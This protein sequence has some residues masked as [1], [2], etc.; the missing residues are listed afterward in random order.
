MSSPRRAAPV[1]R[2][3]GAGR[4]GS[5]AL[6]ALVVLL[7][8]GG[9]GCWE[10]WSET[11]FPQ[12]KWQKAIQ[13]FERVGV[14]DQ[15][16]GFQPPEGTVPVGGIEPSIGR[17]DLEEAARLENPTDPADFRSLTRGK[18][19]YATYC[20]VC[21]GAAGMGDGPVSIAGEQQG[22]FIGVFPLATATGQSD[23]YIW[24]VIRIGNGDTPGY[25]MPGY[26]HIPSLDRWHI[27]NYVRYLQKGGQP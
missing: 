1:R 20:T 18:E 8:S 26:S 14:A 27:V 21:H 22:P 7:V 12:M 25:R 13:A 9:V 4:P 23:G 2:R 16:Q 24:N 10:Q 11:W 3:L 15:T 19:L 17:L 5:H 6:F